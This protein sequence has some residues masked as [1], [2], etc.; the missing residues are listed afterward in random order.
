MNKLNYAYFIRILLI[1]FIFISIILELYFINSYPCKFFVIDITNITIF[2]IPVIIGFF[3]LVPEDKNILITYKPYIIKTIAMVLLVL[4]IYCFISSV[5]K[6]ELLVELKHY[7]GIVR[8][9]I[10]LLSMIISV[11][12]LFNLNSIILNLLIL[13]ILLLF[14]SVYYIISLNPIPIFY[15]V[16]VIIECILCVFV[17]IMIIVGIISVK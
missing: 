9:L 8:S 17:G 1:L 5:V 12:V 4:S 7:E 15:K 13:V 3:L 6:N 11:L 14:S 2:F 16:C 10:F